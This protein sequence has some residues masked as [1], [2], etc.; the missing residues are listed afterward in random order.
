M[1]KLI[2]DTQQRK[3]Q[4]NLILNIDKK[5]LNKITENRTHVCVYIPNNGISEIQKWFNIRKSVNIMHYINRLNE[6]IYM[7]I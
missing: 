4:A 7:I 5:I 2:K 3:L 1:T 6:K